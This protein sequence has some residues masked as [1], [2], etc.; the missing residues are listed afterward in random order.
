MSFSGPKKV[1]N[2]RKRSYGER[3]YCFFVLQCNK[4]QYKGKVVLTATVLTR[5]CK[6]ELAAVGAVLKGL[7]R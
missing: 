6:R 5:N 4:R 3:L 7:I 1:T 2:G